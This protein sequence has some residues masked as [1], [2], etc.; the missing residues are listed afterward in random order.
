[1]PD[2]GAAMHIR[3]GLDGLPLQPREPQLK[4]YQPPGI[5]EAERTKS[6]HTTVTTDGPH[7]DVEEI[8]T[9]NSTVT[10]KTTK[11]T[12]KTTTVTEESD[13]DGGSQ[14]VLYDPYPVQPT[15]ININ[16]HIT[17]FPEMPPQPPVIRKLMNDVTV[18]EGQPVQLE[19]II[20]GNPY[21]MVTW[22]RN[23]Q[24][25]PDSPDFQYQVNEHK[26]SLLITVAYPHDSGLY[27]CKAENPFGTATSSCSVRVTGKFRRMI[28]FIKHCCNL[29]CMHVGHLGN[30]TVLCKN[31]FQC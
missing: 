2:P 21:P 7:S 27:T 1:M 28:W 23:D 13:M 11:T 18:Q 24:P 26:V 16:I 3:I 5:P 31:I 9:E 17:G 4:T 25:I 10:R 14:K 15:N 22:Y 12:K 6:T 20:T 19:C 29:V 8:R 30:P